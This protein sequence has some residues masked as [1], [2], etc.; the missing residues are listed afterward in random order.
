MDELYG[1][2]Y[3]KIDDAV[4]HG[5][6]PNEYADERIQLIKLIDELKGMVG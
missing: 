3:A 1:R 2:I 4:Q 5:M 6:S